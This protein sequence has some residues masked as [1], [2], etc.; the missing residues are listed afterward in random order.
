[1][2]T[3]YFFSSLTRISDLPESTLSVE[4]LSRREWATGAT[5]LPV[6][7]NCDDGV[8]CRLRTCE[9]SNFHALRCNEK[10]AFF[11][12]CHEGAMPGMVPD[13]SRVAVDA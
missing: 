12:H 5:V 1:M 3:K 10:L 7:A 4:P 8:R 9:N 6:T 2:K 13:L 11:L